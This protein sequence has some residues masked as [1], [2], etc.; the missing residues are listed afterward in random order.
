MSGRTA[1]LGAGLAGLT[2]ARAL[3]E[4][5]R[6]V[7]VYD[8]SRGLGGRLAQRRAEGPSGEDL[9]FDHGAQ[10]LTAETPE[11]RELLETLEA[12]GAAARW[13]PEGFDAKD[14]WVGLPGMSGLVRPLAAGLDIWAQKEAIAVELLADGWHVGFADGALE[15]PFEALALALPAPQAARLLPAA[16]EALEAVEMEPCWTLMVAFEAQPG[17]LPEAAAGD[18]PLA[19]IARNAAKPGRP[20]TECW[21]VQ[22][23]PEW[24]REYLELDKAEACDAL[25]RLLGETGVAP[26]VDWAAA[27]R[28]RYARASKP[29]G[30]PVLEIEGPGGERAVLGGDWTLGVKAEH[31]F[32]SGRA[33][34]ERLLA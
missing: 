25:L 16:A 31:A 26:R 12:A 15:G 10:Y 7:V 5:G 30:A 14:R 2:C 1:V 13:S 21:V 22:A 23:S 29:L 33:M 32:L 9:R 4:A 3:A 24:S 6:E 28:W 27:H 8:K 20:G 18:G 19:W 11:F 17:G 34:A